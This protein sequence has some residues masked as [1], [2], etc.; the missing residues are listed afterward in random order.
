MKDE[1]NKLFKVNQWRK[2]IK[3]YHHALMYIKGITDRLDT[4][5][6]TDLKVILGKQQPSQQDR[7][8]AEEL[9]INLLNNLSC[10]SFY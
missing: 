2:A 1:G 4:L 8:D 6:Q 9:M 7:K 3:K 5:D 10:E